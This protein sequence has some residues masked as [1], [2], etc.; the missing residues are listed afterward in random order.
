[1]SIHYINGERSD[2]VP[3]KK[4]LV[5]VMGYASLSIWLY[6]MGEIHTIHKTTQKVN[7]TEAGKKRIRK[8]L[9]ILG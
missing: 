7:I 1:M 5:H 2:E 9:A 8:K 6:V 4:H 3:Y